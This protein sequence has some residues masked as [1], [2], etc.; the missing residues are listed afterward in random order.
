MEIRPA[1]GTDDAA[2]SAV[3]ASTW[4]PDVS[5]GPRP[6]GGAF[7]GP[8]EDPANTLVA[9]IDG[10][11]A[12]YVKLGPPTPLASNRH[13]LLIRGLAVDPAHQRQGVAR[14]LVEAARQEA[15]ARGARRLTLRVLAPNV[16][17]RALYQSCG[18]EVEGVQRQEFLLDG[19]YVDDVLIGA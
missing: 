3:D 1:V 9:V 19:S 6:S 14:A 7:F 16:G 8:E 5:P 17:A 15:T 12:G 10:T 11:V 13:V 4:S 2:L 18:F